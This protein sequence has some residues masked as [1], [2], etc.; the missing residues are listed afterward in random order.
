MKREEYCRAS[1]LLKNGELWM[2]GNQSVSIFDVRQRKYLSLPEAIAS[3]PV[4]SHV[5]VVD[6][7]VYVSTPASVH[8][9][10]F[11]IFDSYLCVCVVSDVP[12]GVYTI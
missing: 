11:V 12:D 6:V 9:A 10:C 7:H 2:A 4:L 1:C 3:H 8:V 5:P